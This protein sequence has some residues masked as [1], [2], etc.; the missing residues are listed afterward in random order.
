MQQPLARG[1]RAGP[2]RAGGQGWT[3]RGG[4]RAPLQFEETGRDEWS[5]YLLDR[6]RNFAIQLDVHRRMITLSVNGGRRNDL[7][8]I[9]DMS[10][11]RPV[12]FALRPEPRRGPDGAAK[13][14]D[15]GDTGADDEGDGSDDAPVG[16]F[17]RERG[18]PAVVFQF[19]EAHHCIVQNEYQMIAYAAGTKFSRSPGWPSRRKHGRL[20]W[21]NGFYRRTTD[22]AVYR[23]H[24]RGA[25]NIGRFACHVVNP[26]Q[27]ELFGGF[28]QLRVV[29]Q[30]SDLFRG[31][32]QP[33]ECADPRRSR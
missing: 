28:A 23:L 2:V 32:E 15:G 25:L 10:A 29:E 33:G 19:A 12:S 13:P 22:S 16:T 11:E 31:R 24:G 27:M 30:S 4:R 7:Y 20:R 17:Y 18:R 21:P 14:D 5:V 6:S 1:F 26:R 8:P 3:N 9:T